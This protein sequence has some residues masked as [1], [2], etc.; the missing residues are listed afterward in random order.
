MR[1]YCIYLPGNARSLDGLKAL[2]DSNHKS[3]G[4]ISIRGFS[5]V[6][7]VSAAEVL[8]EEGLQWTYPL[9]GEKEIGGLTCSAYRTKNHWGRVGCFLSHWLLWKESVK[10]GEGITVFED[11][12]VFTRYFNPVEIA[13]ALGR[14]Y[15]MI[16][17]ND[18][19]GATRLASVYD[20]EL[21]RMTES[22]KDSVVPVPMIDGPKIPQ[23][24]P[25]NSAYIIQPWFAQRL[26]DRVDELG[27]MPNDALA[28][29]QWFPGALGCLT[30]Y[31]TKVSG[32]PSF[33]A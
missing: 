4:S 7:A 25:G 9:E 12:A 11:D 15:G 20:K 23:G 2:L 29:R 8:R 18:P 13:D 1:G 21:R 19:R 22:P 3:G 14:G 5:G 27:A 33:L 17:L 24:L 10:S 32:R 6:W 26:I 30:N 31:A 28:N 16:S